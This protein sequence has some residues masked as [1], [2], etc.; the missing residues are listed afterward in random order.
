MGG[1][2][3]GNNG[4]LIKPRKT[5]LPMRLAYLSM[6]HNFHQLMPHMWQKCY[7]GEDLML[8]KNL[9]GKWVVVYGI[10]VSTPYGIDED[11]VAAYE[12]VSPTNH[13]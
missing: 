9:K 13:E 12:F 8:Q 2:G 10:E 5:P 3:F 1:G 6:T 4:K 7:S 11:T